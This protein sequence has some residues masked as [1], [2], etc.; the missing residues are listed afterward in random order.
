[1]LL[2]DTKTFTS[3]AVDDLDAAR[4]FYG[5][6]LGLE[7]KDNEMGTLE[8]HLADR[9]PVMVYPKPDFQPA[10]Y[11][12]LNFQVPDV[13]QAVDELTGKGVHMERYDRAD[14][15]QDERGIARDGDMAMAWFTDPAG[16][17]LSVLKS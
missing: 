16:N 6:T 15:P 11:T 12:V 7:V 4:T 9:T 1:M 13:D 17:I 14:M 5:Q 8:L 2:H 10:T 3:F